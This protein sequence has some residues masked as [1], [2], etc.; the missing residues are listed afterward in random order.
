M[1]CGSNDTAGTNIVEILSNITTNETRTEQDVTASVELIQLIADNPGALANNQ[2]RQV[3][4]DTVDNLFSTPSEVAENVENMIGETTSIEQSITDGLN[5]V[6]DNT[7]V[8]PGGQVVVNSTQ[9]NVQVVVSRP[10]VNTIR[11]QGI[12]VQGR[13]N[14]V[15]LPPGLL[16]EVLG[17]DLGGGNVTLSVVAVPNQPGTFQPVD[18]T[19]LLGS[20]LI[21]IT[22]R[23]NGR[24]VIVEN[25]PPS[26]L[27]TFEVPRR[28]FRNGQPFCCFY[29][30]I[31]RRWTSE[32]CSVIAQ[33]AASATCAC[34]HLTFFAFLVG[35]NAP[36]G[37]TPLG[38][39]LIAVGVFVVLAMLV[40]G[41]IM[42]GVIFYRKRTK[43]NHLI[44]SSL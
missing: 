4:V 30:E 38:A 40:T 2:T 14:S 44:L 42:I 32:G 28:Q 21:E 31:L 27:V 9:G 11:N 25:L 37:I 7:P 8:S 5:A 12:Q 19:F 24:R 3:V 17:N 26:N 35:P 13:D 39:V 1:L 18:S 6:I 16:M 29:N 33:S 10:T 41:A 15:N 23:E 36:S 20:D 34:N 43:D 22:L